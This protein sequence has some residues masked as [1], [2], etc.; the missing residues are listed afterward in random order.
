ME[1]ELTTWQAIKGIAPIVITIV[2]LLGSLY[3]GKATP[4]ES[5]AL[6]TLLVLLFGFGSK[7]LTV[8]KV[9]EAAKTCSKSIAMI[10][11]LMITASYLTFALSQSSINRHLSSW[12]IEQGFSKVAILAVIGVVYLI[13]G[14][15]MDGSSMIL[16]TIPLM[17]PICKELGV[18]L[19]WLGVYVTLLV[20]I[21]QITPPMGLNLF[22]VQSVDRSAEL[23]DIIKGALP[24]LFIMV[25]F[26]AVLIAFPGMTAWLPI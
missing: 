12:V 4:V 2:V 15:F 17:A 9:Y 3:T 25:F 20:Q 1:E 22:M 26:C 6:G 19:I 23:S 18:D 14:C 8:K 11:I 16:L 5:A 10:L 24:Y 13:L 7:G 21:G